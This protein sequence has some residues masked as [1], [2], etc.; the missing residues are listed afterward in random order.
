[1]INE[2]KIITMTKLALYDKHEGTADR[3]ANDYFRHDYIYKKNLGTRLAVGFGSVVI[4]II[5]WL[6][7]IFVGDEIDV[8]EMNIQEHLMESVFFVLAVIAVYS[9]IGTIQ[10][11]RE[12]YLIQK[13]LDIY[14]ANMRHLDRM[15]ERR[16]RPA[17][18][19]D[20]GRRERP[21][22][23]ERPERSRA[24][25]EAMR[26]ERRRRREEER[27]RELDYEPRTRNYGRR[28]TYRRYGADSK[29]T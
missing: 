10:G 12:Y 13:R 1:M 26:A 11:T 6:S 19:S 17:G 16:R 21:E 27:N 9:L 4:L 8:F 14:Q 29:D 25:I 28:D 7:A 24:E 3:A 18:A 5:Y 22:R 15:N 23:G 20:P 2:Q